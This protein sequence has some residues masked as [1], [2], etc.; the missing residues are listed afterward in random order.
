MNRFQLFWVLILTLGL[1]FTQFSFA[2]P[3]KTRQ[4]LEYLKRGYHLDDAIDELESWGD[5]KIKKEGVI[6][7][8]LDLFE[9]PTLSKSKRLKI[10]KVYGRLLE[11]PREHSALVKSLIKMVRVVE[12]PSI[13]K[14]MLKLLLLTSSNKKN[15]VGQSKLF[16]K[17]LEDIKA[18][19]GKQKF[20]SSLHIEAVAYLVMKPDLKKISLLKSILKHF[21]HKESIPEERKKVYQSIVGLTRFDIGAPSALDLAQRKVLFSQ[22]IQLLESE[23]KKGKGKFSDKL[24][25]SE[26]II[27]LIENIKNLLLDYELIKGRGRAQIALVQILHVKNSDLASKAGDALIKIK[28]LELYKGMKTNPISSV[29][30]LHAKQR[31]KEYKAIQE[32]FKKS[33]ISPKRAAMMSNGKPGGTEEMLALRRNYKMAESLN[34]LSIKILT[35]YVEVLMESEKK[36]LIPSMNSILTFLRKQFFEQEDWKAKAYALEAFKI[37]DPSIIKHKN[38]VE[39]KPIIFSLF[40]DCVKVLLIKK[41]L[42]QLNELKTSVAETLT[43]MSGVDYGEN[44]SLWQ[45]WRVG[46]SGTKLLGKADIS[47]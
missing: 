44:A 7:L 31:I 25:D 5:E 9:K 33:K 32:T 11:K 1:N 38:Y 13:S 42:E 8:L 36:D 17:I 16:H 3:D 6:N 26:E 22:L 46:P 2:A 27:Y 12:S 41:D 10:L 30:L 18:P 24:F 47:P 15:D 39:T 4:V 43:E 40:S 14:K 45:R 28:E 19:L 29:L 21:I 20:N 35:D 34:Q 23:I 37:F